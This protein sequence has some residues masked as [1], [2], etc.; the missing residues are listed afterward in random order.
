M[1][2]WERLPGP[3]RQDKGRVQALLEE[4]LFTEH[5]PCTGKIQ[6]ER[7]FRA[8][9]AMCAKALRQGQGWQM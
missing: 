4:A 3:S 5:L 9:R 6:P 2:A 7:V 8:A 1:D